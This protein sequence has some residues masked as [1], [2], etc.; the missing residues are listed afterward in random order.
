MPCL[1]MKP[2]LGEAQGEG[3]GAGGGGGDGGGAAPGHLQVDER[4]PKALRRALAPLLQRLG[5]EVPVTDDLGSYLLLAR[6][7]GLRQ[8][9]E[10]AHLMPEARYVN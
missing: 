5:V 4:D 3:Q 10:A 9:V 1:G 7:L 6:E 8:Q 2:L